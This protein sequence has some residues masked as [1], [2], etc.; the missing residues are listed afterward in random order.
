MDIERIAEV[1]RKAKAVLPYILEENR[2]TAILMVSIMEDSYRVIKEKNVPCP[3][4]LE[5]K[6]EAV[7]TVIETLYDKVATN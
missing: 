3:P 2:P 5:D 4:E 6:L 1:I 7:L